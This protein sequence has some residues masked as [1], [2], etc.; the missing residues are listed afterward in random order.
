MKEHIADEDV[1]NGCV[2]IDLKRPTIGVDMSKHGVLQENF[3]VE[4]FSFIFIR[5]SLVPLPF[6]R[7]F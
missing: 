2:D 5:T 7:M 1:D 6:G 4:E 3:T